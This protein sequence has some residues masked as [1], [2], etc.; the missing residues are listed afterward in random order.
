VVA[1]QRPRPLPGY[2]RSALPWL[3]AAATLAAAQQIAIRRVGVDGL[4]GDF[5]RLLFLVTTVALMALALRFRQY[6]GAW[7]IAAGIG[8]NL[9]PILAHGGLMPVS[10]HVV[11]ESGYFPEIT[12]DR[13]GHQLGNGKDI[14][15]DRSDIHFE[16]LSD[17]YA[18]S[19][20]VY[21]GNIYSLGDFVLFAGF[22][23]VL[24]QAA[25]SPWLPSRGRAATSAAP[26]A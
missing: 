2:R 15:L 11:H 3:V 23:L 12:Q 26:T 17:R 8:L 4:A 6:L 22:G 20:P 21:G 18:V 14:L 7:L 19:I 1:E 13:I 9:I 16:V 10:Y 25:A 24:L 5:R